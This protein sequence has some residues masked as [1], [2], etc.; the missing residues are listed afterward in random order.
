MDPNAAYEATDLGFETLDQANYNS[1]PEYNVAL[2][3]LSSY[4]L[5]MHS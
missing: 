1:I 2:I 3:T 4:P 5:N